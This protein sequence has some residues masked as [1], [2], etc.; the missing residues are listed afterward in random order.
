MHMGHLTNW[1]YAR[2]IDDIISDLQLHQMSQITSPPLYPTTNSDNVK[3]VNDRTKVPFE[4]PCMKQ[5]LLNLLVSLFP[6]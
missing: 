2:S 1:L 6:V 5:W 4:S 3:A